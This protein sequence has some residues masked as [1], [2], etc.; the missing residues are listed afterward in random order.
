VIVTDVEAETAYVV[1]VKVAVELP[2]ATI[3]EAGTEAAEEL[4][5]ESATRVP[6]AGAAPDRVRVP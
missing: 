6:P 2:A 1:T 4:L 5:L 3:T